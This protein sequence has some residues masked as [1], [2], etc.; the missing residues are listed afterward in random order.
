MGWFPLAT[1]CPDTSRTPTIQLTSTGYRLSPTRLPL[2]PQFRCKSQVQVVTSADPPTLKSEDPMTPSLILTN[3]LEQLK[4]LRERFYLLHYQFIINEYN[5]RTT[6][7]KICTCVYQPGS[8]LNS[9]LS[10]FLWRLHQVD[11]IDY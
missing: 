4:E 3:L 9:V 1:S 11:I 10:G 2:L 7:W 6:R 8:S 5:S